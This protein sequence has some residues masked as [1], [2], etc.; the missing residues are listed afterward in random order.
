MFRIVIDYGNREEYL[1]VSSKWAADII[2]DN[3]RFAAKRNGDYRT[4]FYVEEIKEE[5]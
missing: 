5:N 2:C 3:Y 1:H 4:Q